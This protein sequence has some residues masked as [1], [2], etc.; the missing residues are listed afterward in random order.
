MTAPTTERRITQEI[1]LQAAVAGPAS[2]AV[3]DGAGSVA[4]LWPE[5]P[6]TEANQV[7]ELRVYW[8]EV[9]LAMHHYVRPKQVVLGEREGADVFLSTDGLP[10][11]VFAVVRYV[12]DAY[13]LRFTRDM[14][15]EIGD[16]QRVISLATAKEERLAEFE[17]NSESTYALPLTLQS[18]ALL[19]WGGASLAMRF[20]APA[21][22]VRPRFGKYLDTDYLNATTFAWLAHLL[23]FATFLWAPSLNRATEIDLFAKPNRMAQLITAPPPPTPTTA[24]VLQRMQ[25]EL[26]ANR[27]PDAQAHAVSRRRSSSRP[28]GH[29]PQPI[30]QQA[31]V[32]NSF[33]A[34]LG[35][36]RPGGAGALLGG[37]GAGNLAGAAQNVLG[38]AGA[39]SAKG[40][41]AGLGVRGAG[42]LTG[43]GGGTQRGVQGIGTAGR[44]GGG[45]GTYGGGVGLGAGR[46]RAVI[47]LEVPQIEG[48]LAAEVIKKVIDANRQQIQYCYEEGLLQVK[49]LGGRVV[50][51]WVIGGDGSVLS[52]HILQTSMHNAQVENCLVRKIRGWKFPAPAGGGSVQV[53][54]PF[55]FRET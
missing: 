3:S 20:V 30:N 31:A 44:L 27:P 22:L 25:R 40:G 18:R 14:E 35:G 53:N 19:H 28:A 12:D 38:T 11:A 23:L 21:T 49:N 55:V 9:L 10:E 43:G 17:T 15:G 37:G 2:G 6:L 48:A 45:S 7:L 46:A 47:A 39:A 41:I 8:G 32:A 50:V 34:L 36:G 16:G 24:A 13:V 54:Y 4:G 26:E 33:R 42:P 51:R 5:A 52:A 1:L 29:S